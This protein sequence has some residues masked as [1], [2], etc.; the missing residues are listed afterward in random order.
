MCAV[1]CIGFVDAEEVLVEW[2]VTCTHAVRM[3]AA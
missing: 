3:A 1:G 2:D